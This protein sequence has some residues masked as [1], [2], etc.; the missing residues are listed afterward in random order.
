MDD[1][2]SEFIVETAELLASAERSL[3][4]LDAARSDR[5]AV[6]EIFR[7]AHTIKGN[8]AFF[9]LYAIADVTHALE[10]ALAAARDGRVIPDD[11]F[12][13]GLFAGFDAVKALFAR[14]KGGDPPG[15]PPEGIV[16][17]LAALA[18]RTE[19]GDGTAHIPPPASPAPAPDPPQEE[20]TGPDAP[21][22]SRAPAAA[23]RT[24]PPVEE[25]LRVRV[26]H[27][28][29]LIEQIGELV[30]IRSG[31]RHADR[32]LA[33][34]ELS[35]LHLRMD[36]SLRK[37]R[38]L[39]LSLRMLP[40]S[41][42]FDRY[43]RL[44]RDLAVKTGKKVRLAVAGGETELDRNIIE[45][46]AD[47][48]LHL[49]RNSVDHGI[50]P[51]ELRELSGKDPTGTLSL[52][53]RHVENH[54]VIEVRDDGSGIDRE[55]V[56]RKA[57]EAGL[58]D[59]QAAGTLSLDDV[60]QLIFEPGLSTRDRATELSGRGVGMDVVRSRV[61]SLHGTIHAQSV[62]GEGARFELRLPLT[63]AILQVLLVRS[64]GGLFGLPLLSVE[65]TARFNPALVEREPGLEFLNL[66]GEAVRIAP[67]DA[68]L[69]H[70]DPGAAPRH[71][72]MI[73]HGE[74][75]VALTVERLA[76]KAEVV[77]KPLGPWLGRVP[78]V[79][80]AAAL[81]DGS[82]VP[83]LEIGALLRERLHD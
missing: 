18:E 13:A 66:R 81:G 1:L 43:P 55:A 60:I 64:A 19:D 57:V 48:L 25:T 51:P 73:R 39:S 30:T 52:S 35:R 38:D 44:V 24:A 61:E 77:L 15:D 79:M 71:A 37:L 8:S 12:M 34:P 49:V 42:L 26:E 5:A 4:A 68:L 16:A 67:L 62:P 41:R 21:D 69:G 83:V 76:G 65:E 6:D 11:R 23:E 29:R 82:L 45:E 32:R 72:V 20:E 22:G 7:A 63:L 46:L 74:R 47:P 17:R 53:A 78:G 50:E 70:P 9:D 10:S 2:L 28:N 14:V 75:R 58:V 54:V 33:D 27:L 40:V 3:V 59:R 56:L 31:L 80:G 36:K